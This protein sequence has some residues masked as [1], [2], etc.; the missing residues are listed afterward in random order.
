MP[1][2]MI[3]APTGGRPNVMGSSIATVAMVP[4]PGSTPTSVPTRAPTRHSRRLIGVKATPKPR[5]RLEK[6]SAITPSLN[7]ETREKLQRQPQR[8]RKEQTAADRQANADNDGFLPFRFRSA[9]RGDHEAGESRDHQAQRPDRDRKG[10]NGQRYEQWASPSIDRQSWAVDQKPHHGNAGTQRQQ[11]TPNMRGAVPA[12]N[13][14]PRM[15]CRSLDA[16]NANS[17]IAIRTMPP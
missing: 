11:N 1:A 16:H 13:E 8:I 2:S 17:A 10:D 15:P 5:A 12:P 4:M 7:Q 9:Q 3:S 14:N 6:S